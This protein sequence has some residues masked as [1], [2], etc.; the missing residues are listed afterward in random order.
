MSDKE[1]ALQSVTD[2]EGDW[3]FSKRKLYRTLLEYYGHCNDELYGGV[4]PRDTVINLPWHT[5]EHM[6]RHSIVLNCFC[7]K[8]EAV[9]G[10]ALFIQIVL[11]LTV[12]YVRA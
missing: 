6:E 11:T 3:A 12:T 10:T 1:G 4:G 9:D 8:T 5:E 2:V 7:I